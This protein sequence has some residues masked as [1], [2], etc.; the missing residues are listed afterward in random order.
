MTPKTKNSKLYTK[1][2]FP[3]MMTMMNTMR[4]D[5]ILLEKG[6][7]RVDDQ[8]MGGFPSFATVG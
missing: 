4:R 3:T 6:G 2:S 5:E 7:S 8:K 1:T